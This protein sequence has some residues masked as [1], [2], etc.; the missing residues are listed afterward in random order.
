MSDSKPESKREVPVEA[1]PGP[2]LPEQHDFYK[3]P[4]KFGHVPVAE[5][6]LGWDPKERYEK[7]YP[8]VQLPVQV[9]EQYEFGSPDLEPNQLFFGDNLHV[10]RSLPSEIFERQVEA[11][12]RPGDVLLRAL[13]QRRV[14]E[15]AARGFCGAGGRRRH[16]RADR[17]GPRPAWSRMR[18]RSCGARQPA[19]RASRKP[20]SRSATS[21]VTPSN[22]RS[23]AAERA[24][25]RHHPC[26][27][28]VPAHSAEER[29]TGGGGSTRRPHD[30][31]CARGEERRRRRRQ[32]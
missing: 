1:E 6:P 21:S 2:A 7:L 24:R 8:R 5:E 31:A 16:R 3:M 28:R 19:L 4:A 15:R 9:V 30:S 14:A 26:P 11:L 17:R 22:R 32:H 18:L 23:A 13:D 20:T 25:P 29:H 27:R 10:M 12:A